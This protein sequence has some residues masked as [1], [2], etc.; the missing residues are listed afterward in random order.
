MTDV[1]IGQLQ[2]EG[3]DKAEATAM[4][5]D[6]IALHAQRK[7]IALIAET[8]HVHDVPHVA[9]TT[10]EPVAHLKEDAKKGADLLV[11]QPRHL[12][13]PYG[14][15]AI[16]EGNAREEVTVRSSEPRW[17]PPF[18]DGPPVREVVATLVVIEGTTAHAHQAGIPISAPGWDPETV[19]ASDVVCHDCGGAL[20]SDRGDLRILVCP[21]LHGL[22]PRD[23][24]PT[25]PDG[26]V[27]CGRKATG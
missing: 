6:L 7:A 21:D 2:A 5:N 14:K 22:R 4:A 16:G 3:Y 9:I 10:T 24:V 18:P 17:S 15:L 19:D 27:E 20:V 1:L 25:Q 8:A 12:G 26:A 11:L 13:T 23:L